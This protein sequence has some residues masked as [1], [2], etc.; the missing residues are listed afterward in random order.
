MVKTYAKWGGIILLVLG[1][2]G[3]FAR[4]QLFN[5]LNS[6]TIEDIIHVVAGL[7][8]V[9]FGFR[10]TG[11]QARTWSYVFG[12]VFLL[13]GIVGFLDKSVYGLLPKVGL[14]TVDNIVHLIYGVVGLWAGY[15]YKG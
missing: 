9:W 11:A 1:V 4:D 7:I 2:V 3:L 12:V 5:V 15:S 10:G 6:E 14:G 13:V 8:L